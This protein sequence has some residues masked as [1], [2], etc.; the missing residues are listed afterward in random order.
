MRLFYY[1]IKKFIFEVFVGQSDIIPLAKKLLDSC[2]DLSGDELRH[3]FIDSLAKYAHEQ[4][5]KER[6]AEKK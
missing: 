6:E 1:Q 2:K 5:V 4:A 3:E